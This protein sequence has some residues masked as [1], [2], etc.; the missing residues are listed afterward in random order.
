[1]ELLV[2]FSYFHVTEAS[3]EFSR[4]H[5]SA[6][7][8]QQYIY[9]PD[10]AR[11]IRSHFRTYILFCLHCNRS[12]LRADS[13]TLLCYQVD[14]ALQSVKRNCAGTP[15]Q[16]FSILP[17]TMVSML[18]FMD[19]SDLKCWHCGRPGLSVSF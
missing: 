16:V 18:L 7:R 2:F 11:N 10:S 14:S 4:I 1:M 19:L 9:A 15:I 3:D 13:D 6:R 12:P 17:K 5:Q 8:T